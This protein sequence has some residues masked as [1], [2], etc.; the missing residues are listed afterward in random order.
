MDTKRTAQGDIAGKVWPALP[1]EEWK[2]PQDTLHLWTQIVGKRRIEIMESQH[3]DRPWITF[4]LASIAQLMI[5]LDISIRAAPRGA[6][7]RSYRGA[8]NSF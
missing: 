3:N 5:I 7:L 6:M 2:D 4:A 8:R 1:Y